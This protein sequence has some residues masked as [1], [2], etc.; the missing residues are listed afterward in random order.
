MY[1]LHQKNE[2]NIEW[3]KYDPKCKIPDIVKEL[4]YVAFEVEDIYEAIKDHKIII[5]PNSPPL[6][7]VL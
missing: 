4:P 3:M 7:K 1:I 2:F 6:E 5:E